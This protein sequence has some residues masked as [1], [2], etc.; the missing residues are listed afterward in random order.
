MHVDD[1]KGLS[2]SNIGHTK[3][4]TPHRTFTL[5]NVLQV[6]HIQKPL[7]S[8]QK[9]YLNNNFYLEFH[10]FVFYIKDLNTKALLL[11]CQSKDGLYVL[12]KSFV[13]SIPQTYWS[14]CLSVS[15]DLWYRWLG[16]HTSCI[17]SFLV[18]KNKIACNSK[19]LNF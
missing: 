8:V 16:H 1:G 3:I 7:L 18:L 12:T 10:P 5:S 6:P 15:A 2:I 11:F 14:L 17:F 9:F 19:C 13:T 4:H